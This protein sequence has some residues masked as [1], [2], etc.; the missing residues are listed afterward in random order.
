MLRRLMN[1]LRSCWKKETLPLTE[2]EAQE[3]L[4]V[5]E[6]RRAFGKFMASPIGDDLAEDLFFDTCADLCCKYPKSKQAIEFK[7]KY[8]C[9]PSDRYRQKEREE[10]QKNHCSTHGES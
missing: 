7:R 10:Y 4:F 6:Y 3:R 5:Q 1:R 2:E 8:A 9:T